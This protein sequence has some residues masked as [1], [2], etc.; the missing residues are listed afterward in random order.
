M[1][2]EAREELYA[3][4]VETLVP[5][6]GKEFKLTPLGEVKVG[7]RPAVGVRV[8]HEG[9]RDINL[10]FDKEKYHLLKVERTV[11]DFM[12]GGQEVRQETAYGDY[13]DV[14]GIATAH[15]FDIKRDGKDYVDGEM[16]EVKL[17]EKLDDSLFTKP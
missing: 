7:A 15:K 14:E 9:R 16:T 10:F 3:A 1:M 12:A 4:G 2:A 11:K 17:H 8:S 5:L 6:T 13:K